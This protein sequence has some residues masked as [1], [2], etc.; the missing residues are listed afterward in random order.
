MFSLRKWN[1]S[2]IV[3]FIFNLNP[4][5]KHMI[6]KHGKASSKSEN[7]TPGSSDGVHWVY[8]MIFLD[9]RRKKRRERWGKEREKRGKD[10]RGR[11]FSVE[12]L[13]SPL[14]VIILMI[15]L[16]VFSFTLSVIHGTDII[17]P[18]GEGEGL[19]FLGT[20][21]IQGW[22]AHMRKQHRGH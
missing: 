6:Q 2:I 20:F 15:L 9:K 10:R 21:L 18:G 22:Q 12:S 11:S 4:S 5:L 16:A 19:M 1:F 14:S 8:N 13:Y 3:Y 17:I 7:K